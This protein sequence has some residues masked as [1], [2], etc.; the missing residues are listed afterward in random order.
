MAKGLDIRRRIKSI[1]STRSITKAMQMVAASK[2]RRAQ[3]QA[4]RSRSFAQ[5]ALEI[6]AAVS[7]KITDYS[8]YLL[9]KSDGKRFLVVLITSNKG[10]C[11][12]LN[13]NA[14]RKALEFVQERTAEGADFHF[15][16]IGKKGR[17]T[18]LRFGQKVLADF[19]DI[20]D[21]ITPL[22]VL[23]LTKYL[24]D[25]YRMGKFDRVYVVYNHFFSVL[26]QKP[27]IKRVVPLGRDL[28]ESLKEIEERYSQDAGSYD[29]IL[30][31][32]PQEVLEE[33]LPRFVEMQIYQSLLEAQASEHS[34]RMVAMKSA[35]EAA[36]DL[37][38]DLTLTYNKTRQAGI[39]Q[40]IAEIVG[41]V[42][43]L[44]PK[45]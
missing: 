34:A 7:E 6:L 13:T 4:L 9:Q 12:S 19:S 29:Y 24:L 14:I 44:K 32:S 20:A 43:A 25:E 35:T 22:Q 36:G 38:D 27:L 8:H 41:A 30:E 42:E 3:E 5:K 23:Q 26:N 15:I 40:E 11:G 17:D 31:P 28:L 2:M 1:K 21:S 10:L 16:T 18:L 45:S 39:T 37:I 33:L